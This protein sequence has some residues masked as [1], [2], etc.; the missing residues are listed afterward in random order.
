MSE[1]VGTTAASQM[2]SMSSKLS[3]GRSL[4]TSSCRT[5]F[6]SSFFFSWTV[7]VPSRGVL[8]AS[9]REHQVLFRHLLNYHISNYFFTTETGWQSSPRSLAAVA[10][11]TEV[12][13]ASP[14]VQHAVLRHTNRFPQFD[15]GTSDRSSLHHS[16]ISPLSRK[17]AA[18]H[19][20][21][22]GPYIHLA[23]GP[24]GGIPI[25]GSKCKGVRPVA[26]RRSGRRR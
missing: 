17:S 2:R 12:A 11:W 5:P 23:A 26:H 10:A 15:R 19:P 13:A 21:F 3:S 14:C 1:L 20:F 24:T 4:T 22:N 16:W 18:V 9:F 7:C 8:N 6:A 25:N